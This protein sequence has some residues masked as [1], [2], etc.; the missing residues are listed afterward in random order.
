MPQADKREK[1]AIVDYIAARGGLLS[2]EATKHGWAKNGLP[3][4]ALR[5]LITERIVAPRVL[6]SIPLRVVWQLRQDHRAP[7]VL[8][9]LGR[10][11][12]EFK[13]KDGAGGL[14]L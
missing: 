12:A 8:E 1:E 6:T 11:C 2:E 14:K 10:L 5:E 4:A 3:L 13:I 9:R 7:A